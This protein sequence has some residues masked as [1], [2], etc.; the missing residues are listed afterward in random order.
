MRPISTKD[1]Q[2][3]MREHSR[4]EKKAHVCLYSSFTC[5]QEGNPFVL[6]TISSNVGLGAVLLQEIEVEDRWPMLV[7]NYYPEK[8][9]TGYRNEII[10]GVENFRSFLYGKEFWLETGLNPCPICM[11]STEV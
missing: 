10:V 1:W 4:H 3:S 8:P 2:I 9:S 11:I 5:F 7:R 6:R